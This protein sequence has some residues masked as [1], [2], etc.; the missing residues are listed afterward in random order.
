[1]TTKTGIIY[2]HLTSKLIII[3]KNNSFSYFIH[4]HHILFFKAWK[5]VFLS[6]T[7]IWHN[8]EHRKC[9]PRYH[10]MTRSACESTKK[11]TLWFVFIYIRSNSFKKRISWNFYKMSILHF[12][13]RWYASEYNTCETFFWNAILFEISLSFFDWSSKLAVGNYY[14]QQFLLPFIIQLLSLFIFSRDVV[15]VSTSINSYI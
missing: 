1:M 14:N 5:L 12:N 4:F 3:W 8:I 9:F 7:A 15:F 11:F 10:R 6:K 13:H 2:K